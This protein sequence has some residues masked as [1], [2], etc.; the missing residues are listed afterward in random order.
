MIPLNEEQG[1]RIKNIFWCRINKRV[2]QGI[3]NRYL[4]ETIAEL[5]EQSPEEELA[6]YK[7]PM[8]GRLT[9]ELVKAGADNNPDEKEMVHCAACMFCYHGKFRDFKA[10]ACYQPDW[11]GGKS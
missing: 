9:I 11:N 3:L 2:D 10:N 5:T 8:C 6:G 4:E 7:C 1:T